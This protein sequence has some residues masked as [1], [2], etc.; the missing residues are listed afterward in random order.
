MPR[1]R[2]GAGDLNDT[3]VSSGLAQGLSG[4][5]DQWHTVE[6]SDSLLLVGL[7][8]AGALLLFICSE[9]AADA[10]RPELL[11]IRVRGGSLRQLVRPDARPDGLVPCC[12]RW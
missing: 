10:Y 7:F 4:F 12:R 9:L 3:A 1:I 11:V 5:T 6:R 8:V 2:L